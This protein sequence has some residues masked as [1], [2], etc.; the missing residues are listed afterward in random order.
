MNIPLLRH[1]G[2]LSPKLATKSITFKAARPEPGE[3]N[4]RLEFSRLGVQ[5]VSLAREVLAD[6]CR[7]GTDYD[8][9]IGRGLGVISPGLLLSGQGHTVAR[10]QLHPNGVP[11]PQLKGMALVGL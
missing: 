10:W 1:F 11:S 2:N 4:A 3:T 7:P 8:L 6:L 9:H 5:C